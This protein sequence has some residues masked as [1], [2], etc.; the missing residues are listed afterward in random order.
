MS[1]LTDILA[2]RAELFGISVTVIDLL[3]EDSKTKLITCLESGRPS[4]CFSF[5][6]IGMGLRVEAGNLWTSLNIPF[7]SLMGDAPF[8]APYLH[9]AEGP[10]LFHV[11]ASEDFRQ[12]YCDIMGGKNFSSVFGGFYP[13][14]PLA[15]ETPWH[16]R[17]LEIVYV[18]TGVD[19]ES[20]RAKWTE[21]PNKLR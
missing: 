6:G 8:Y 2:K 11:Y 17:D 14:N 20:L 5:Q 12:F 13:P 4:F 3:Q 19:S 21:F 10:T 18:K 15:D 1:R 16:D 7:I 9:A